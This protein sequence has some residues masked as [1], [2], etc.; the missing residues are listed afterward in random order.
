MIV[1]VKDASGKSERCNIPGG[2]PLGAALSAHKDAIERVQIN[3][4]FRDDW[5]SYVG[6]DG[7]DDRVTIFVRTGDFGLSALISFIV[8]QLVS[9]AISAL[10][11]LLTPKPDKP[12]FNNRREESTA[13]AGLHNAVESGSPR[14]FVLGQ[15]R[16]YGTVISTSVKVADDG[17]SMKGSVLY[18]M[19]RTDGNGV[20][21]IEDIIINEQPIDNHPDIAVSIRLGTTSQD[22]IPGF[23]NVSQVFSDNRTFTPTQSI[24]YSTRS[25]N[26]NQIRAVIAFSSL[27]SFSS[28]GKA[29]GNSCQV[30]VERKLTS[31]P[32]ENFVEISG[33]PFTF[34]GQSQAPLYFPLEITVADVGLGDAWDFRFTKATTATGLNAPPDPQLFNVEEIQFTSRN[35]AN[36]ALLAL[37]NIPSADFPSLEQLKVSALV[38]GNLIP[39]PDGLGGYTVKHTRERVWIL[40]Y[41]VTSKELGLGARW[42]PE[43]FDEV[44]GQS[45]QDYY[46]ELVTGHSGNEVRDLCDVIVNQRQD[47]WDWI[48]RICG[49][50][51]AKFVPSG[52]KWRY[53]IDRPRSPLMLISEPGNLIENSV[54]AEPLQPDPAINRVIVEYKDEDNFDL[55]NVIQLV[56]P[57]FTPGDPIVSDSV[58]LDTIARESQAA[59]E[60]MYYRKRQALVRRHWQAKG[61]LE[62]LFAEPMDL[63]YL[64]Y[65]TASHLRGWSGFARGGTINSVVLDQLVELE[66]SET[67]QIVIAH[68]AANMVETR[69][70]TTAAGKRGSVTVSSNFSAAP[71]DGDV[72][73]LDKV[74]TTF[75]TVRVEDITIGDDEP[76]NI[77]LSDYIAEVYTADAL[78]SKSTRRFFDLTRTLPLPLRA[79][80]VSEEIAQ[81]RDGSTRSTLMFDV[82][83]GFNNVTGLAQAGNTDRIFLDVIEPPIDDFYLNW[84]IEIVEGT[85]AGQT[86]TI[87]G[88][89]ED[90]RALVDTLWTT[91]PDATSRYRLFK[92]RFGEL[93]GFRVEIS[94]DSVTWNDLETYAGFRGEYRERVEGGLSYFRFTPISHGTENLLAR[95]TTSITT[96]GDTSA[97]AAPD[98]ATLT[99]YLKTVTIDI[100]QQRPTAEDLVGFEIEYWLGQAQIGTLLR[101]VQVPAPQDNAVSGFMVRRH[102]EGFSEQNYGDV[103]DARV[104]SRDLSN[105]KSAPIDVNAVVLQD[106]DTG[107]IGAGALTEFAEFVNDAAILVQSGGTTP[108]EV[109]SVT[110]ATV[111]RPVLLDAHASIENQD[112]Q[113]LSNIFFELRR[114]GAYAG[115]V[116]IQDSALYTLALDEVK[117]VRVARVDWPAPGTYTYKLW[118][119]QSP[120]FL[121][122]FDVLRRRLL[123]LEIKDKSVAT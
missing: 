80:K 36:D 56:D 122:S 11:S 4:R 85:G 79:V 30:K 65:P 48:K 5:E 88:Y 82:T 8:S 60:G 1:T 22:V 95:W 17:K 74:V 63:A 43:E 18:F 104:R 32:V 12:N 66:T 40:R 64:Y 105:N 100:F 55:P 25:D 119:L 92:E 42:E 46:N 90:R 111:G 47:G 76:I 39:V 109:A 29:R 61:S 57:D 71:A 96:T 114:G 6:G 3:G 106:I 118:A 98:H 14:F 77:V 49:E 44:W 7:N 62:F 75:R 45:E 38:K 26:V 103:I 35:Y 70:I 73:S 112:I 86:R 9:L 27:V 115:S 117:T 20:E 41:L 107:D 50:G 72:W 51:R 53:I 31:D 10:V 89:T 87:V 120:N 97:P 58:K 110:L 101:T 37:E 28:K 15:R 34:H 67:Y 91:A 52:R 68:K 113:A 99:S 54:V 116:L 108:V 33:S 83:P 69:T 23:N 2:K 84:Q 102:T 123:A 59:R 94:S 16:V 13:I 24:I 81:N 21:S 93:T 78:P 121:D 19:S